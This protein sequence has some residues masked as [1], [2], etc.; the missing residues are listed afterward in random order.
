MKTVQEEFQIT[1]GEKE[2]IIRG[3]AKRFRDYVVVASENSVRK[4]IADMWNLPYRSEDK[5]T[6]NLSL[7]QVM[8]DCLVELGAHR[9]KS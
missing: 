9:R 6:L 7:S 5:I 1:E 3:I 4:C 2:V 8:A